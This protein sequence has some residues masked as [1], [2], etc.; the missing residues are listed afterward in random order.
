[1]TLPNRLPTAASKPFTN[2]CDAVRR[3]SCPA[4]STSKR[5]C[6]LSAAGNRRPNTLRCLWGSLVSFLRM[7][8]EEGKCIE[9][10]TRSDLETF[11]EHEQDR[12]IQITTIKTK[13]ACVRAFLRYLVEEG[14][15]LPTV[16]GRRM[17][18]KL[19]DRLPR[20]MELEDLR[21]L[22][23]VID[24]PQDRAMVL[25]LLRTGMRI[26]ELLNLKVRDISL[27]ERRIEIYEAQKTRVGR[28]KWDCH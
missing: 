16:L 7:I 20:A 19:P 8:Q 22:L 24:Q 3:W 14:M 6:A 2:S 4:K 25:V 23:S 17:C 1:M 21:K 12:G 18:L 10:L 15:V 5:I 13:V 27:K 11:I 26:G 9:A 28:P